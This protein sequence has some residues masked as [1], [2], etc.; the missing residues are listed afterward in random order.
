MSHWILNFLA[1]ISGESTGG[2]VNKTDYSGDLL[3]SVEAKRRCFEDNP[4]RPDI[5]DGLGG[6]SAGD[7]GGIASLE[8]TR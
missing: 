1:Y 2:T 8:L 7:F 5:D 4:G 3:L 6:E